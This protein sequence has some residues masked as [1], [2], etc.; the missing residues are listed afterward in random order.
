MACILGIDPGSRHTG[1][2]IV[3]GQG[4]RLTHVTSGTINVP[5]KLSLPNRL[6][7]IREH[8]AKIIA[9]WSPDECAVEDV[10]FA[11]NVKSALVLGQA[12]GAAVLAGVTAGLE[13]FE[14]SALQ[15]KQAVVGY[16]KADKDQVIQMIRYL[17]GI[18]G[19]LSAH[20]ADALAV[21][22]CHLNTR[23]SQTRWYLDRKT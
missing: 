7:F 21:S 8:L 18:R 11:K 16:G 4:N 19:K 23:A 13:V 9:Q 2:G 1:Y 5:T 12:R 6:G 17:L 10:F 3:E 20:A 14:Y 15:I 22:I